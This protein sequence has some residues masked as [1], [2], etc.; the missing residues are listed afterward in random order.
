MDG[1]MDVE[2]GRSSYMSNQNHFSNVMMTTMAF[3]MAVSLVYLTMHTIKE[4][5]KMLVPKE[6]RHLI[7]DKRKRLERL[8]KLYRVV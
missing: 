4:L 8:K 3:I 6:Y 1:N 5:E 7:E 2:H